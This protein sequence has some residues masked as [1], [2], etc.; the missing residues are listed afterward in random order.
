MVIFEGAHLLTAKQMLRY[1]APTRPRCRGV[2]AGF[3]HLAASR[4]GG[5]GSGSSPT[6]ATNPMVQLLP[7]VMRAKGWLKG[8]KL[9]E[10]WL[11]RNATDYPEFSAPVVDVVTMRDVLASPQ[12]RALF[13]KIKAERIWARPA[14]VERLKQNLLTLVGPNKVNFDFIFQNPVDAEEFYVN[15]RAHTDHDWVFNDI[16]AALGRFNLRC[17]VAGTVEPKVGSGNNIFLAKIEKVAVYVYDSYDFENWWEPLGFWDLENNIVSPLPFENGIGVFNL[18]FRLHRWLK[19]KGGDFKVY[20]DY[21][22]IPL[23]TPTE[24]EFVVP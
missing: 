18:N 4:V 12:G 21:E 24:V 17:T 6:E 23:A 3:Q 9:M 2:S 16:T 20:S 22:F 8:A 19:K 10:T 1:C 15:F 14:A 13:E 5:L 11:S 7:G